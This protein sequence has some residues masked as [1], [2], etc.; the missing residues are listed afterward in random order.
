M[1]GSY[2][3]EINRPNFL[4]E[5]KLHSFEIN[6]LDK[7]QTMLEKLVSIIRFSYASNYR[8]ALSEKIRHFYDLHFLYQN[9]E[10]HLFLNSSDFNVTFNE[11]IKHDRLA[12]DN[13]RNWVDKSL[14][15]SP[16]ITDFKSIW[17]DLSEKYESELSIYAYRQIPEN[18]DIYMSLKSIL[19]RLK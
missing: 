15:E 4:D 11:L 14:S 12:F 2:L 19:A 9:K 17:D 10:C 7:K 18:E 13:P 5:Y 6:V 16:L 1:I 3:E 8:Q